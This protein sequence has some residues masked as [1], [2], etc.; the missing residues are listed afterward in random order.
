VAEY[1]PDIENRLFEIEHENMA[2]AG[3]MGR[4]GEIN[5]MMRRIL[6]D[7]FVPFHEMYA[8]APYCHGLEALY[9]AVNVVDRYLSR[10]TVARTQLQL[11]GVCAMYIA[12]KFECT[13]V[14][15]VEALAHICANVYTDQEI[16]A[17]ECNML[18]ALFFPLERPDG[19]AFHRVLPSR[20]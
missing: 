14:P 17:M 5:S 7:W 3:Y 15:T 6:V 20:E 4:Q 12:C 10:R 11:V 9:L 8:A 16:L 18:V 1:I 13:R 19:Y 2:D